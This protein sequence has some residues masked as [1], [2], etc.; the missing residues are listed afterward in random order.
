MMK[1]CGKSV[2]KGIAIGPAV[3]VKDKER[4]ITY[5]ETEDSEEEI[6]KVKGGVESAK[7]ELRILYEKALAEMGESSA[8]IFEVQQMILEDEDYLDAIFSLIRTEKV[9]AEHAV[10]AAG[11]SFSKMFAGMDDSYIKARAA[12]VMD[13]SYRLAQ[14]ILGGD[15]MD[16]DLKEPSVIV[17]DDLSPGEVVRLERE[18]VLAIVTV[19]GSLNSH[20]AIL[21]RMMGAPTLVGVPLDLDKIHTGMKVIADGIQGEA[22]FEPDEAV[23]EELKC[24]I[25]KEQ[26]NKRLLREMKGKENIT[27][28]GKKIHVYANIGSVGD[29]GDALENDAGGIGLFRSECLY[30]GRKDFPTENEQFHA[31]REIL[32]LMGEKKVVVRTFDIGSDKGAEYFHFKKEMNPALGYRGIRV[33]LKQPDIFKTQLRALLRAA[34]YGNLSILYPMITSMEEIEKISEIID[35]VKK[36]LHEKQTVFKVPEQGIMIETPAAV[37]ISDQLARKAEFFSIGTNDLTQYT[38]AVDRLNEDLDDFYNPHHE[39]VLRMIQ[40]V[41][42]NAHRCG[43][44]VGICGELGADLKLTER[45]VKMGIDGLS[46]PPSTILPL[47]KQIRE[48]S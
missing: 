8:A 46:V 7:K 12:D 10:Y 27:L 35:E 32:R 24:R 29:V 21:A 39:A 18:K 28:G 19:H 22:I 41:I 38:L 37:M 34:A 1:F 25:Q 17:A 14:N 33:C 16:F 23:C 3:V 15:T 2:Y 42:D 36:E 4:R 45:F 26:E 5:R 30:L 20:T 47:R 48:L 13:I 6:Q 44:W 31:Y 11:D 40:M 9:N 43:K